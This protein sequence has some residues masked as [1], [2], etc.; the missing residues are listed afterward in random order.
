M[1]PLYTHYAPTIH[2]LCTHY[3]LTIR[4]KGDV[5]AT[6]DAESIYMTISMFFSSI[7]YA[8]TIGEATHLVQNMDETSRS[9]N[10]QSDMVSSRLQVPP[11]QTVQTVL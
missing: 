9:H 5:S 3:A 10:R 4:F 1:H 11:V 7:L 2:P 8:Y 6:T